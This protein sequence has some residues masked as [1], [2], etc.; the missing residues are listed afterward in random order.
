MKRSAETYF[1]LDCTNPQ[2]HIFNWRS[3][4][5]AA[6]LPEEQLELAGA[7]LNL[8]ES[9]TA[10]AGNQ[11][12]ALAWCQE[13]VAIFSVQLPENDSRLAKARG[14]ESNL[15]G[16]SGGKADVERMVRRG[17]AILVDVDR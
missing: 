11:Q 8:A 7:L 13:A 4:C 12:K 2:Q 6:T 10:G 14:L 17:D 1:G 5:A 15:S 16:S 3:T 9:E